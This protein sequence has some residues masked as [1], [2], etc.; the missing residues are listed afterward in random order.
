MGYYAE[1]DVILPDTARKI[2]GAIPSK[3]K[4]GKISISTDALIKFF[5]E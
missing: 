4:K 2:N 5:R 3:S 1:Y